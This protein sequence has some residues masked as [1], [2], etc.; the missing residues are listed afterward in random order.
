MLLRSVAA[1]G[2]LV[3]CAEAISAPQSGIVKAGAAS[4]ASAGS[5]TTV[6]QT[7]DRAVID[8]QSFN[9]SAGESVRFDQPSAQSAVLNRVTGAQLSSLQGSL[10]ANGQLYLVNPNG[11]LI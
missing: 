1:T 10:T 4:I 11:I 3:V 2:C 9:I 6:T 8:W 7:T 5:T